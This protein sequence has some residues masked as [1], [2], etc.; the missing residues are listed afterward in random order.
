MKT[1][2]SIDHKETRTT[3]KKPAIIQFAVFTVLFVAWFVMQL[4]D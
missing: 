3:V 4:H 2:A 1:A